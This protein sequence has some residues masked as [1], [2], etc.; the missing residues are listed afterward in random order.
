MPKMSRLEAKDLLPF[1]EVKTSRSG[2]SGGQ[3]VNKVES[4]VTLSFIVD[5]ADIFSDEEKARIKSRL[6]NRLQADGAVQVSSQESRS[7]LENRA[8]ALHKLVVLL[9]AARQPTKQR[10]VTKPTKASVTARLEAKRK[11]ALRKINRKKD[12]E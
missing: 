4:K 6:Y 5:N 12:W 11:Q 3:H 10:K 2:G 1:V 7:Q 9:E 8:I